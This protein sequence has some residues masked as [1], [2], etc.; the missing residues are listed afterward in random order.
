MRHVWV[1]CMIWLT[2]VRHE[3]KL[4]WTEVIMINWIC[5]FP[6]KELKKQR[7]NE[8]SKYLDG[9]V[10]FARWRQC[11]PTSDMCFLRPIWVYVTASRLVHPFLHRSPQCSHTLQMGRSSPLK[12]SPSN[13]GI[14]TPHL[15]HGSLGPPESSNQAL[16]ISSDV[17]AQLTAECPYTLQRDAPSP[18][19]L[20]LPMG[21]VDPH[22]MG[23][24]I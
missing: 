24:H 2:E 19:K 15:T 10:V 1:W 16:S 3:V 23:G 13:G 7:K 17:F 14:W 20:P 4:D 8:W 6:L 18:S 9:S 11:A 5:E 21:Y 22:L 12:T